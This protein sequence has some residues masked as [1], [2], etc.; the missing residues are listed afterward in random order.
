MVNINIYNK[1]R[2]T[3]EGVN[4]MLK[5]RVAIVTG[6]TRGIGKAVAIMMAISGSQV[7][8]TYSNNEQE[9]KE[10]QREINELG[11][12]ITIVK[13]DV[14]NL[15]QCEGFIKKIIEDYGAIHILVNN[16]GV[17]RDGLLVNMSEED[18]DAV[19][20]TNL[21][22][23]FYMTKLVAK[24][25]M[26][27]R[28]GRIINMASVSG[29]IGIAGQANYAASKAGIIGFTKAVAKEL[30]YRN[31]TV[32]AIA[33]GFINT[34]MNNRLPERIKSS[35]LEQIPLRRFGR[36]EEVAEL[37]VYLASDKASYIT[38]QVLHIDGGMWM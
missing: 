5:E 9:A 3:K 23:T 15:V 24:Q 14:K 29:I 37:A 28:Q 13:C 32:N 2:S 8:V 17:V 12:S 6:G 27:Q 38:G 36:V 34:D 11:Y 25:M 31:I 18:F 21:K 26:K 10:F 19:L 22:G 20:N 4:K 16:A 1:T 30:A 33:P 7:I 35:A